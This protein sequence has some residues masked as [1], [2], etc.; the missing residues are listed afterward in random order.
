MSETSTYNVIFWSQTFLLTTFFG[1]N[2]FFTQNFLGH[3]IFLTQHLLTLINATYLYYYLI[4][5][6]YQIIFFNGFWKFWLK[7]VGGYL[8]EI[9]TSWNLRNSDMSLGWGGVWRGCHYFKTDFE[10]CTLPFSEDPVQVWLRILRLPP[11]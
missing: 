6:Y 8:A 10:G 9:N 11:G 7:W 4:I 5:Y 1:R 3:N 2:N